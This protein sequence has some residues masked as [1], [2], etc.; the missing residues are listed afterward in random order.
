MSE[1]RG[2]K[3]ITDSTNPPKWSMITLRFKESPRHLAI[4][5]FA[6]LLGV[7]V[8]VYIIGLITKDISAFAPDWIQDQYGLTRPEPPV[9]DGPTTKS[10]GQIAYELYCSITGQKA[11]WAAQNQEAYESWGQEFLEM[12]GHAQCHLSSEKEGEQ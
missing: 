3:P 1:P 11:D 8:N 10:L 12:T 4:N 6:K 7:S 5:N 9:P 2:R